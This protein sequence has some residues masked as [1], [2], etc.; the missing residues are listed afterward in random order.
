MSYTP[1]VVA[2]D[3]RQSSIRTRLI[4]TQ[5]RG[6]RNREFQVNHSISKGGR[7]RTGNLRQ[8]LQR[9]PEGHSLA[10]DLID[11]GASLDELH[12]DHIAASCETTS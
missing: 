12:D 7:E 6:R 1:N 8:M 3:C 11:K 9:I 10:A 5:L 2:A 4:D